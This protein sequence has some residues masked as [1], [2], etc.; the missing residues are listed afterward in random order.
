MQ[1]EDMKIS[2][3]VPYARNPRRNANAVD[4]VVASIKE[5]G[6]L[7]P[8]VIDA[9]FVVVAGHTWLLAAKR[10]GLTNLRRNK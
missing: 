6:F 5:F 8:I 2:D 7:Q 4:A 10:L 9:N 1:T 3:L